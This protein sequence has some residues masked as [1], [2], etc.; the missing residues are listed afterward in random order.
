MA[1]GRLPGACTAKLQPDTSLLP[2]LAPIV[3][4]RS[5]A[6]IVN[7]PQGQPCVAVVDRLGER[8]FYAFFFVV[9]DSDRRKRVEE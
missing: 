9:N 6:D 7:K 4:R 2:V 5:K 1:L 3:T 8:A